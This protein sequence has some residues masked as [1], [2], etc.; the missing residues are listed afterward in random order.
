[1]PDSVEP[2]ERPLVTLIAPAFDEAANA[3]ALVEFFRRVRAGHPDLDFE[4]IVVDDGSTDATGRLVRDAAAPDE[5]VRVLTLSRRFGSHVALSAGLASSKGDCAI[6]VSTDIQEPVEVIGRFLDSWLAGHDIVWG[7][8]ATRADG[9]W[10]RN[11]FSR[12]FSR[13]FQRFSGLH[14]YP[15]EGPS[16]ALLSRR[17][18]E[19]LTRLPE[20]NRNLWAICAWLGFEQATISF[21]QLPRH[22]GQSKWSTAD[23]LKLMVD[24]IV[25]FSVKPFVITLVLGL[26]LGSGGL[27]ALA[28]LLVVG[29]IAGSLA[30]WG[31]VLAVVFLLAGVQLTVFGGFGLYLWRVAE[32]TRSRP[33]YVLR[34]P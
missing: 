7:V 24:S 30:G 16:Q 21:H 4:L 9:R 17:V 31:L 19:L 11:L 18:V 20:R 14:S 33:L 3:E 26:L 10:V 29:L 32:D 8:R 2:Q 27:I 23:R 5:A 25:G 13:V 34:D 1:M 22:A 28:A 15:A 12:R 6:S